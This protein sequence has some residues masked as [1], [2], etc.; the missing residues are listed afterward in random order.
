MKSSI[1]LLAF[2]SLVIRSCTTAYKTG[3]TPDDVYF[4][5]ERP[6]NEYVNVEKEND[7][8]YEGSDEYYAFRMLSTILSGGP[9]SRLNKT[10]VDERQLA[11]VAQAI[12]EAQRATIVYT[13]PGGAAATC[14]GRTSSAPSLAHACDAP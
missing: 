6:A 5:P 10:V 7:R 13:F 8:Y 11:V 12:P 4:S 9:S 3:Q 2:S 14:T 1:L